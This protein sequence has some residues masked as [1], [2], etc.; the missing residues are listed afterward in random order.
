MSQRMSL[1]KNRTKLKLATANVIL[2]ANAFVWYLLAFNGLRTLLSQ[3]NASTS[4]TLLIIGIN[5]GA[6]AVSA[7]LGII[8]R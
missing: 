3:Q 7:L 5:T 1:G 2:V 6:I 8:H 4:E